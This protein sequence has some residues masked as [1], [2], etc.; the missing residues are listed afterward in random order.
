[1]LRGLY[2]AGSAMVT[3]AKRIDV[4]SNNLANIDTVSFK[5][6]EVLQESFEEV[7]VRKRGG[8]HN[9]KIY[10][11]EDFSFSEYDGKFLLNA[12]NAF[13]KMD[14]KSELNYSHSAEIRVDDE[15]F[16]STFYR[17]GNGSLYPTKGHKIHGKDGYIQVNGELSF[18]DKGNVLEDGNIVDNILYKPSQYVIGTMGSGVRV[19]RTETLFEQGQ[20]ERTDNPLDFAI[21][22]KGFFKVESPFGELYTR[23]GRFKIN[24]FQELVTSEGFNVVGL[25]GH[26]VMDGDNLQINH[27]GEVVVDGVTVDKLALYNINNTFDLEKAGSGYYKPEAGFEISVEE[28]TADIRQGYIEK[29]NASNLDEMI[30]LLELYRNYETN[31]RMV[32]AYDS[33]LDKAVNS[34][35]RR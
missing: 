21:D 18:D 20:L 35:G 11:S 17:D 27:F 8:L 6:D 9:D 31:Q 30:T 14:G 19:E 10:S 1:M 24:K 2:T 23:D 33:T 26:I 5:K 12:P 22:G 15:G 34:I 25:D 3:N 4:V 7:L 32:T 13:I 28:F 16:L 29:S